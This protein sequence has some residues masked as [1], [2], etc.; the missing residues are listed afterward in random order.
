MMEC[1]KCNQEIGEYECFLVDK[2][3]LAI[4]QYLDPS[5]PLVEIGKYSMKKESICLKC[6]N[7]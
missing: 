5:Y 6:R 1:Q 2:E 7:P 3:H 4:H